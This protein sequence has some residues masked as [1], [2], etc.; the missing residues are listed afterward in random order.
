[1]MRIILPWGPSINDYYGYTYTGRFYLHE[2]VH[3][4]RK[5]VAKITDEFRAHDALV[6]YDCP[7]AML[8]EL[9]P[10]SKRRY[11]VDNRTKGVFD[12]LEHAGVYPD[13]MLVRDCRQIKRHKVKFGKIIVTIT[14][15]TKLQEVI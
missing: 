7:M 10:P 9:F 3:K 1:M 8:I 5:D 4:F 12:A 11:D 13:D 14:E 15:L 2:R 6:Y